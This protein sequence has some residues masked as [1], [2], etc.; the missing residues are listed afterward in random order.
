MHPQ[1]QGGWWVGWLVVVLITSI[2]GLITLPTTGEANGDVSWTPIGPDGGTMF[3]ITAD[4]NNPLVLFARSMAGISRTTDGGATWELVRPYYQARGRGPILIDP[5]NSDMMVT[6]QE[7]GSYLRSL[8]GGTTWT[9]R[10]AGV[11]MTS[12]AI[13]AAGGNTLWVTGDDEVLKSVD[14]GQNWT[15]LPF[16][17]N[18]IAV[19]IVAHPTIPGKVYV[20]GLSGSLHV[21]EDGGTSWS[22]R[23]GLGSFRIE[24][25]DTDSNTLYAI[26]GGT[27]VLR[28]TNDG[29]S[30]SS[31]NSGLSGLITSLVIDPH[32]STRLYATVNNG[33]IYRTTIDG[34]AWEATHAGLPDGGSP[35]GGQLAITAGNPA[36]LFYADD[37]VYKTVDEGDSWN[38]SGT[39]ISAINFEGVTAN[40]DMPATLFT[41]PWRARLYHSEDGG[42]TWGYTQPAPGVEPRR[43]VVAPSHSDIIYMGTVAD[44]IYRSTNG[45]MTW[46]AANGGIPSEDYDYVVNL[47]VSPDNPL[48][49]VAALDIGRMYYSTNGG[50]SWAMVLDLNEAWQDVTFV[51]TDDSTVWAISDYRLHKSTDGGATWTIPTVTGL[52]VGG[53][54][55]KYALAVHPTDPLKL[56]VSS[57]NATAGGLYR[58][59]D[60]GAT[61]EPLPTGLPTDARI[62][63]IWIDPTTP[64][65]LLIAANRPVF[66][67]PV[68]TGYGVY[69]ST[70]GGD[71]WAPLND[72]LD[73]LAVQQLSGVGE[74]VYATTTFGGLWRLGDAPIV[75]TPTPSSTGAPTHT[76]T[77]T[78]T[79][80]PLPPTHTATATVSPTATPFPQDA[81]CSTVNTTI[82]TGNPVTDLIFP[83]TSAVVTDLDLIVVVD[84]PAVGELEYELFNSERTV[85]LFQ[86]SS[87]SG[88]DINHRLDDE[89]DTAIAAC[90][91]DPAPAYPAGAR[92]IPAESLAA[93]DGDLLNDGWHFSIADNTAGNDGTFV[94]WCLVPVMAP[95]PTVT[96]MPTRTPTTTPTPIPGTA[97]PTATGTPTTLPGTLTATPTATATA[98][99]HPTVTSTATGTPTTMP[100]TITATPTGTLTATPTGIPSTSTPTATVT[101]TVL[102]TEGNRLYLP[103]IQVV[104]PTAVRPQR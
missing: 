21:S 43:I 91:N 50:D 58:S 41:A 30:W 86:G 33:D 49:V 5:T 65:T 27:G 81:I 104:A 46:V 64:D 88:D 61:W 99:L 12:I 51:P 45:G 93:F 75:I 2:A 28:S 3:E 4:P 25:I 82:T 8:D 73:H 55:W 78:P 95:V 14:G 24:G 66:G 87:C 15:E 11:E 10:G 40:P 76:P 83:G 70:N 67:Q 85:S 16:V 71:S 34:T 98:T 68:P 31:F 60:G 53:G 72:G 101:A 102:P 17:P 103:L 97:T 54:N 26:K 80:T 38:F 89:G 18:V 77:A 62:N 22:Q 84:H 36:T 100:G 39:G 42:A 1:R 79:G 37:G 23:G 9:V 94:A 92:L 74:T 96:A 19:E 29:V 48:H 35:T 59:T 20:K 32:D 52:P 63:D 7:S 90:G 56:Y 69:R 6:M 13:D 47:D 44:G 57:T